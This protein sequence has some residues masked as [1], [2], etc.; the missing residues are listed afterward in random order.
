[1][2]R[3][4]ADT[5][6]NQIK[7][8]GRRV[9]LE[10]SAHANRVYFRWRG[11]SPH[12]GLVYLD[13]EV[14]IGWLDFPN[15]D[16]AVFWGVIDLPNAAG[17]GISIHGVRVAKQPVEEPLEWEAFE[18]LVSDSQENEDASEADPAP[19]AMILRMQEEG[20]AV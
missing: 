7:T 3:T 6:N 15:A 16:G 5:V 20:S 18:A 8:R 17:P 13:H 10:S 1:M 14:Q 9:K 19:T 4:L 2:K 12:D 11:Q